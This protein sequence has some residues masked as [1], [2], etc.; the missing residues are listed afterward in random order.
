M[1]WIDHLKK[2]INK[3]K[4]SKTKRGF[5]LVCTNIEYVC[6]TSLISIEVYNRINE[7]FCGAFKLPLNN[8]LPLGMASNIQM[9]HSILDVSE[10]VFNQVV[11]E[12]A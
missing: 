7:L 9:F 10:I 11:K 1:D 2:S 12:V 3:T 4:F 8:G 5:F 6:G